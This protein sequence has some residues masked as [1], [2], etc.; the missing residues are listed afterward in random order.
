MLFAALAAVFGMLALNG[1]PQPYHPVFN[2]PGFAIASR[3]RFFLCIEAGR[4][5]V[6]P[7]RRRAS[8]CAGSGPPR[9]RRCSRDARSV[10]PTAPRLARPRPAGRRSAPL[11]ARRGGDGLPAGHARP[12][13]VQAVARERDLRRPALGAPA[14]RRAPSPA[15]RCARTT[16][17]L[18]RARSGSDFVTEIPVKVTPELL[19]RGQERS[20]RSSARPATAAPAA[21]TA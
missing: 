9:C 20:S 21:A 10:V 15:A 12:A 4:P 7:R 14:R 19:A 5:E 16:R 17:P 2:V 6:R 11:V 13:E 8:S 18:H 3:D 1:F